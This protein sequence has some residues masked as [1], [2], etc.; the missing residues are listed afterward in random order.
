MLGE[1]CI[2]CF[3]SDGSSALHQRCIGPPALRAGHCAGGGSGSGTG[4]DSQL[5]VEE[6]GTAA[7]CPN[8]ESAADAC[9]VAILLLLASVGRKRRQECL[10]PA[11]RGT[12][13]G[14]MSW[15]HLPALVAW[16]TPLHELCGVGRGRAWLL[17]GSPPVV[18]QLH[19]VAAPGSVPS[20]C[21]RLRRLVLPCAACGGLGS[22]PACTQTRRGGRMLCAMSRALQL[23]P[24]TTVVAASCQLSSDHCVDAP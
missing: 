6:G 7:C 19:C 21:S 2:T 14:L 10:C 20:S 16:R 24:D 11:A 9:L 1:R 22:D 13:C 4:A 5:F 17:F 15:W 18:L 23:A 8:R 3:C 12:T